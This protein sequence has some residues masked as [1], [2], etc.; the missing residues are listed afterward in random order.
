VNLN[1]VA[2][3]VLSDLET[4]IE[5]TKGKVNVEDLPVIE[6]DPLQMHLLLQNL[7]SNGLKFHK[8]DEP[9]LVR[10]YAECSKDNRRVM[11]FVEDNGI[12]FEEQY[13]DR[14]FQP[15]Q[16]LHGISQY[17]GSGMGLAICRKIIER[18]A[19]T[20][21]ARSTPGKGATFVITLPIHQPR[22]GNS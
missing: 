1:E 7:V 13:L 9:P 18:H 4:R 15:F 2:E 10:L 6:A 16:R 8:T 12:G 19:G 22:Q 14:I 5:R 3:E 20:I 11:I 17:E 21:T